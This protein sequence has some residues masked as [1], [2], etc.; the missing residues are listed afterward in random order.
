MAS[1]TALYDA[2]VLYPAPL[3]DLLMHLAMTDLFRARWTDQIHDEWIRNVLTNRPDLK[4]DQLERTRQLMNAHVLDCLVT[5]Y[6]NL[7]DGSALPDP[8]DRHVLA[9]AIR[10]G[11]DVIVTYN[12][13]D[14]PKRILDPL[15]IEAQHPDMFVARLLDLDAPAICAAAR[16]QRQSLRNPPKTVDEFLKILARQQLPQTV[17]KFREFAAL[18]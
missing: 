7:I 1:F 6:E 4:R 18:L 8:D 3:R 15:G 12:L 17:T 14:F 11:A 9:A 10:A 2:C 13:D 5:G 16:R